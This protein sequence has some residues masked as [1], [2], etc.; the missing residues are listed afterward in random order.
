MVF[1]GRQPAGA[2]PCRLGFGED[3]ALRL[4]V[5]DAVEFTPTAVAHPDGRLAGLV[6][7]DENRLFA[8][9]IGKVGV[10]T[11]PPCAIRD[12]SPRTTCC[13]VT[14]DSRPSSCT[15]HLTGSRKS[16][17]SGPS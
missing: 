15:V 13:G 12:V 8:V 7:V 11:T 1:G 16:I 2:N 10:S 6:I 17:N 5:H 3:D 4:A 14:G 9:L